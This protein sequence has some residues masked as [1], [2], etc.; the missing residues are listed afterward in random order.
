MD[1]SMAEWMDQWLGEI[2]RGRAL[3]LGPGEGQCSL[4][5]A[6]RGF[7]VEAVEQDPEKARALR[8]AGAGLG[9]TVH[10]L[11]LRDFAFAPDEYQLILAEAVLHFLPP[12]ELWSIADRIVGS[13]QPDGCFIAEVFTIDDPGYAASK[14]MGLLELEPN[15]FQQAEGAGV[16]HYFAPGEFQRV[17]HSLTC[18]AYDEIR[19]LD[20][21]AEPGYRASATL[22][23]RK[24]R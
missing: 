11:D 8:Q 18:L 10:N 12:S 7:Q 2:R 9:I 14:T 20:P 15:T 22:V 21:N 19:T 6:Q 13:L 16:L 4:W 23:A 5:L 1:C 3:D 24:E 17:F